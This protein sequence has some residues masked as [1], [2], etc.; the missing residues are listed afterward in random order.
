MLGIKKIEKPIAA[1]IYFFPLVILIHTFKHEHNQNI[2]LCI[3]YTSS[4]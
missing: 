4:H 1:F 2:F 3:F